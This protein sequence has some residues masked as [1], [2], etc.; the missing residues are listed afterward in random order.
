MR[1]ALVRRRR[2]DRAYG[3]NRRTHGGLGIGLGRISV[4]NKVIVSSEK[5][6]MRNGSLAQ[7]SEVIT[8]A[9]P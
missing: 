9:D 6:G 4:Q 8:M 5:A 7:A 1:A 3:R 2:P